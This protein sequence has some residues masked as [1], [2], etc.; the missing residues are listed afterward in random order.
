MR[1][2][3]FLNVQILLTSALLCPRLRLTLL[4]GTQGKKKEFARIV[5]YPIAPRWRRPRARLQHGAE[6]QREASNEGAQ[7][8]SPLSD[9]KPLERPRWARCCQL[10]L[11]GL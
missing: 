2:L 8:A 1:A 10:E 5:T 4:T 11:L 9:H 3:D 6:Q 7:M